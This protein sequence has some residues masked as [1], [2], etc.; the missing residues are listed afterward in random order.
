MKRNSRAILA[1]TMAVECRLQVIYTETP[2]HTAAHTTATTLLS[3]E[4][5][6]SALHIS[7]ARQEPDERQK[8]LRQ[9]LSSCSATSEKRVVNSKHD[10]ANA[11]SPNI[12]LHL[13]GME[14]IL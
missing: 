4:A 6:A 2:L 8:M 11:S 13:N 9:I 10:G 3:G 12:K 7:C 1:P 14:S 5:Q